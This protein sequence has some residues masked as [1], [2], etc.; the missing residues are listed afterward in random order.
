M[1]LEICSVTVWDWG[2]TRFLRSTQTPSPR[3]PRFSDGNIFGP[4][5]DDEAP[6]SVAVGQ[7]VAA[8]LRCPSLLLLSSRWVD[9]P[10]PLIV[11]Q[12]YCVLCF[13]IYRNVCLSILCSEK[14]MTRSMCLSCWCEQK[15]IGRSICFSAI[16]LVPRLVR[17]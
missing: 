4:D 10:L 6:L 15:S 16:L 13:V 7:V 9:L 2:D 11:Y 17:D 5:D 14:F 8:A 12:S 1:S 3:R